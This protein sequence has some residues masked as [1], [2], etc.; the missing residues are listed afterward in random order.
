MVVHDRVQT[1]QWLQEKVN[2]EKVIQEIK[3]KRK[4]R[5]VWTVV[6]IQSLACVVILLLAV[7]FRFAGGS[8]YEELRRGFYRAL[9]KNELMTVMSR[10]WDKEPFDDAEY[11]EDGSVK[12]EGF[13]EPSG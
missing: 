9:E 5:G 3:P 10:L 2:R 7:L 12:Q 1:E 4:R 8:A 13:T 6:G 11:A